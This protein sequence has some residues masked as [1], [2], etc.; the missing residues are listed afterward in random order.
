MIGYQDEIPLTPSALGVALGST[1][2]KAIFRIVNRC[3]VVRFGLQIEGA[4]AHATAAVVAF[5][6]RITAG[7][8]TGRVDAALGN[9]TTGGT[10]TKPASVS[11]AGK[12]LYKVPTALVV[13]K[14]GEEV[15]V[16][17]TT[18]QGEALAATP[19]LIVRPTPET[20][21]NEPNALASA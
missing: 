21:A 6:K 2:D 18:A 11:S 17:V 13:L 12:H 9:G 19:F 16:E 15:V 7:S 4:S 10:I 3:E 20:L 1:G 8:D 14:P 5:D